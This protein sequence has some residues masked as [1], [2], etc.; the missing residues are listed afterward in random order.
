MS[1]CVESAGSVQSQTVLVVTAR[2]VL[3]TFAFSKLFYLEHIISN[4]ILGNML[5]SVRARG[6]GRENALL[7][8]ADT[9]SVLT[10][11]AQMTLLCLSFFIF[12]TQ[13]MSALQ[14][15]RETTSVSARIGSLIPR[16][17]PGRS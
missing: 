4:K 11:G 9:G 1:A 7:N 16:R 6:R 2:L 5:A 15:R 12:R 3:S 8:E 10:R 14:G 13:T 17:A